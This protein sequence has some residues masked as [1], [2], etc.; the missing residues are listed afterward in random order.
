MKLVL[1]LSEDES[2]A[3]ATRKLAKASE[4]S[5]SLAA[6]LDSINEIVEIMDAS[7]R[8]TASAGGTFQSTRRV[9][10]EGYQVVIEAS[11]GTAAD[12]S[13]IQKIRRLFTSS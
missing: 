9:E 8:S 2:A 11:F 1:R 6:A 13:F 3:L 7:G 10:G 4:G 12:R 5:A